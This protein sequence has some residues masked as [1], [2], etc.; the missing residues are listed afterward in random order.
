[1]SE[2][3]I[4][5]AFTA[6]NIGTKNARDS[7]IAAKGA[8]IF[9]SRHTNIWLREQ[10]NCLITEGNN[11]KANIL[12]L[13]GAMKNMKAELKRHVSIINVVLSECLIPAWEQLFFR[14]IKRAEEKITYLE[15][16]IEAT[17]KNQEEE[18][19]TASLEE[20]YLK[21]LEKDNEN[22]HLRIFMLSEKSSALTASMKINQQSYLQLCCH[23][24]KLKRELQECK[25]T[26]GEEDEVFTKM[27]HQIW[28]L[29]EYIQEYK[30]KIQVL[31]D[32]EKSL[33]DELSA[34]AK[35]KVRHQSKLPGKF[36]NLHPKSLMYELARAELE[37]K[38]RREEKFVKKQLC[39]G[40]TKITWVLIGLWHFAG[41]LLVIVLTVLL[42]TVFI[43][44]ACLSN[45]T[46]TEAYQR[47]VWQFLD[48]Y[49]Q[50][51]MQLY[52]TG[53]LPK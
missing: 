14:R 53:I 52:S 50:P 32:R 22:L 46:V 31:Q 7:W 4:S 40:R 13:Q 44:T 29:E 5:E 42:V 28:E 9:Q 3:K 37:E 26:C 15:T 8:S 47:P 18:T 33:Q 48:Y 25:L 1:M 43:L 36:L 20:Q 16:E 21:K 49:I 45:H 6:V 12:D 39:G 30:V 41:V 34:V 24:N 38:M 17:K 19:V 35:D 11:I 10:I 23:V 2:A 51:Y 27:K